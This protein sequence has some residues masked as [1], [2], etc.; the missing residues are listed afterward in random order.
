[1]GFDA[2][3]N[4][5]TGANPN[6]G[7]EEERWAVDHDPSRVAADPRNH[8]VYAPTDESDYA[9]W[10]RA[11]ANAMAATSSD[12]SHLTAEH[13]IPR[14]LV[15]TCDLARVATLLRARKC[16]DEYGYA[17]WNE[18]LNYCEDCDAYDCGCY[19][20]QQGWDTTGAEDWKSAAQFAS[21]KLLPDGLLQ[22]T[23]AS[24]NIPAYADAVIRGNTVSSDYSDQKQVNDV[25]HTPPVVSGPPDPLHTMIHAAVKSAAV[26]IETLLASESLDETYTYT[27]HEYD[28][29]LA[30]HTTERLA[31]AA[32]AHLKHLF[33]AGPIKP[34]PTMA[35]DQEFD[36]EDPDTDARW[37]TMIMRDVT[38]SMPVKGGLRTK[39]WRLTDAGAYIR[40][41]ERQLTDGRLFGQ[42]RRGK[43]PGSVLIDTSGSMHLTLEEIEEIMDLAPG[44]LIATYSGDD[45]IGYLTVVSKKGRRAKRE[46]LHC[47]LYGNVI[48]GPALRWLAKQHA[49]RVWV[50][51]GGVFGAGDAWS[52]KF[53]EE[54]EAICSHYHITRM[55]SMQDLIIA[56]ARGA[57]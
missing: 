16:I 57:L 35:E 27:E 40:R 36:W 8:T 10:A 52:P 18:E 46:D 20:E 23:L 21:P 42:T 26:A 15:E 31:L 33:S 25:I 37:G 7:S 48:D 1:M 17:F 53:K 56:R 44:V 9:V 13:G 50:S 28:K 11:I 51:D 38:L 30:S 54:C 4:L 29:L 24:K 19:E 49:P 32:W 14:W 12:F 41:P 39:K 47:G 3:P 45:D 34:P 6:L 22:F 55:D 43:A 2:L 5:F